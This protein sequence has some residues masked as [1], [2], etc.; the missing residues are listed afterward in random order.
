M[1]LWGSI[2]EFPL[3]SVLQF[4]SGQRHS[5]ILEIQDFEEH[6]CI[7]LSR[8]RIEAITMPLSDEALG[9]RLVA[10]GFLT[11][12]QVKQCWMESSQEDNEH[13]VVASLLA[14]AEGGDTE[15]LVE[16]VNR[17]TA[18]QVMQLMYWSTGTFRLSVPSHP[19]RFP[20]VPSLD[21]EN[22]LL[23]AY[24]RVDEGERPAREKV[25]IEEELCVTCTLECSAE[26]KRRYLKPDVCLWRNMPSILKDPLFSHG[27]KVKRIILE[28]GDEGDLDFL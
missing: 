13:P 27:R 22:L 21:I 28:E 12:K 17:H 20:V 3:F 1:I 15:A 6:G 14:M 26:I 5:G 2:R 4:V 16:A 18:D 11:A 25:P 19:V 23:E 10:A 8:G 7:Y 24:R 9:A